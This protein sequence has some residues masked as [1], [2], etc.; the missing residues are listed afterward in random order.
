MNFTEAL[1][2][3]DLP[4]LNIHTGGQWGKLEIG[5][6]R[7]KCFSKPFHSLKK[8]HSR[9]KYITFPLRGL[10][11]LKRQIGNRRRCLPLLKCSWRILR[12]P[13]NEKTK[14]DEVKKF[15][16]KGNGGY[17]TGLPANIQTFKNMTWGRIAR[18]LNLPQARARRRERDE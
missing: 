18:T 14:K 6:G 2:F 12:E 16:P 11:N 9:E 17:T 5:K 7:D 3:Q 10:R 13:D 15:I 4:R 8:Q 1:V